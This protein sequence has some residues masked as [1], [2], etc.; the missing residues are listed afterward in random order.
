VAVA[1]AEIGLVTN[2][3]VLNQWAN[4]AAT[5]EE[6]LYYLDNRNLS[7]WILG[8]VILYS[9]ADAYVDAALFD[10]DESPEL[11]FDVLPQRD[12]GGGIAGTYR[13]NLCIRL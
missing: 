10:F 7:F 11:S 9:M 12:P 8:A 1:G 4:T 2:A 13:I 6:R 3:I 5:E